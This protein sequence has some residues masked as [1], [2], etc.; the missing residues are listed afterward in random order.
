MKNK[1]KKSMIDV[2]VVFDCEEC[3]ASLH[4]CD[5]CKTVFEAED[6]VYCAE[7]RHV[8]ES[9]IIEMEKLE[10]DYTSLPDSIHQ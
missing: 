7:N 9:C 8:C 3:M 6:E 5:R 2:N 1:Y 10:S 4:W